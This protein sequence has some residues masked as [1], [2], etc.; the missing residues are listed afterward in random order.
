M[1]LF[2]RNRLLNIH[3]PK[4]SDLRRII[5]CRS[6]IK[7]KFFTDEVGL[8]LGSSGQLFR[9]LVM[10]MSEKRY[11]SQKTLL[12]LQYFFVI[13]VVKYRFYLVGQQ[14]Y[15]PWTTGTLSA[16]PLDPRGKLWKR[17]LHRL[18]PCLV[19]HCTSM[20]VLLR[21]KM[22]SWWFTRQNIE[23]LNKLAAPSP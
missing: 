7:V 3:L 19:F 16:S 2:Y 17:L 15:P 10:T 9:L 18:P 1:A 8:A 6:L 20:S 12:D 21:I 5:N 14:N 22:S 11:N 23:Y 13:W 4:R